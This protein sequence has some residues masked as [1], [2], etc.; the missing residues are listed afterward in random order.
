MKRMLCLFS[1]CLL[2]LASFSIANAETTFTINNVLAEATPD[3]CY[4]GVGVDYPNGI[5]GYNP[6]AGPICPETI[7]DVTTGL[8]T[9]VKEKYNQTYVWGLTRSGNSLWFGTGANIYCLTAGAYLGFED[10][11]AGSRSVCE[12]DDSM[13]YRK[14]IVY[15]TSRGDFRPPKMYEY[16]LAS[17]GTGTGTLIDRTP[18]SDPNLKLV[19]GLR[20]AGSHN[21]VVF[22]AGDARTGGIMMFAWDAV[23]KQYLGSRR[24]TQWGSAVNMS[25]RK[26]L[27]VK[28][29][30]YT[31]VGRD[32][33]LGYIVRWTGTR[34]SPFSFVTVGT[35]IST[36]REFAEYID[37]SGRSRL[38]VDS[39][40]VY[41]SPPI[42]SAYGLP[43]STSFWRTVWTPWNY[44]PDRLT[45]MGYG[46][47]GIHQFDG[48]LYWSTD[49]VPMRAG[50][51]HENCTYNWGWPC[52]GE[53]QNDA[54]YNEL[55]NGTWRATTLWRGRNLETAN[56]EIQL[57]YG[58]SELPMYSGATRSFDVVSTG[59]TPLWG[60]SGYE[61]KNDLGETIVQPNM[62]N[63]YTWTMDV[64]AGKLWLGTYDV[65]GGADLWR[66]D[67]SD[68]PWGVKREDGNGVGDRNNYGIRTMEVSADGKI[69]F[70]GMAT[71]VN[72][73]G[74]PSSSRFGPG[75]ELRALRFDAPV[76]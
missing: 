62:Y 50:Y 47:A 12:Y 59:W 54:E 32:E 74:S 34:T 23:T 43:R 72:L 49:M 2:I 13:V 35:I 9:S 17:D 46:G 68:A 29:Q 10:P 36:P 38:A 18:S 1:L 28:G 61:E 60:H 67:S 5:S 55:F 45:T 16:I 8:T 41:L 56:P 39:Q 64:A 4:A 70:L 65:G 37:N 24:L 76:P 53:P 44:E 63:A 75:W 14:G 40:A 26:W 6:N 7:T 19:V 66:L 11:E 51:L 33:G 31:G 57:L 48:W 58:E 20:S 25:I 3:E 22:M 42:T 27:V 71:N 52:Y 30:L 73:M 15:D 69:L 21:G